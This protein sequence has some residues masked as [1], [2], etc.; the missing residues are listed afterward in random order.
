MIHEQSFYWSWTAGF[1][2]FWMMLISFSKIYVMKTINDLLTLG[3]QKIP[4]EHVINELDE[5]EFL[6]YFLTG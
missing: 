5:L 3:S 2:L 6:D 4:K 1:T